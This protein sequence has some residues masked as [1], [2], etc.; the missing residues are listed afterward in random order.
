M[1]RQELINRYR[2]DIVLPM[3]YGNTI[4]LTDVAQ[5]F[6]TLSAFHRYDPT[7]NMSIK[8]DLETPLKLKPKDKFEIYSTHGHPNIFK[9]RIVK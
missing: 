3:L 6:C 8:I 1:P 4:V 5:H 9:A 2:E 7:T